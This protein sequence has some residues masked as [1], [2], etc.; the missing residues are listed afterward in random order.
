MQTDAQ[1][2][3]ALKYRKKNTRTFTLTLYPKDADIAEWLDAQPKK[4]EA[5]KAAIRAQLRA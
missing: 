2:R 4:A 3:A 1:R 5:V